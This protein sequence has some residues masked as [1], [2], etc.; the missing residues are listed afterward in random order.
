VPPELV[1]TNLHIVREDDYYKVQLAGT[2][3]RALP[4]SA[5]PPVADPLDVFKA[6]LAGPPFHLKITEKSDEKSVA[7]AL[8]KSNSPIDTSVPGWLS[9]LANSVSGRP[10]TSKSTP[11]EDHFV[12]EGI[13][14]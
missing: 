8:P 2:L 11:Q 4:V 13:M 1:V 6:K 3:Q 14:R 5:N 9:R 7:A 10:S 12:I